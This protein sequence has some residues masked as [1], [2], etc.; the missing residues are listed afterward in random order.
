MRRSFLWEPT[1]YS[2]AGYELGLGGT[3]GEVSNKLACPQRGPDPARSTFLHHPETAARNQD[4]E[5]VN[6]PHIVVRKS[7]SRLL[8]GSSAR[9]ARSMVASFPFLCIASPSK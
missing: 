1:V 2:A 3:H 8:S 9:T 6:C 5:Y 7:P 4:S